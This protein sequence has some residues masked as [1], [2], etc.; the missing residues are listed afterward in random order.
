MNV[1][2]IT[3]PE[4]K[5]IVSKLTEQFGITHIPQLL[6]RTGKDKIRAFSGHMSKDE[7]TKLSQLARVEIIG[8]YVMREE[9][10][11]RLSL[12]GALLFKEQISKNKLQISKEQLDQWMRG[13][14]LQQKHLPGM[15][16]VAY[17]SD[18][19]GCGRS[20]GE[21]VTNFVPKD[22]RVRQKTSLLPKG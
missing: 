11:L 12:D 2:F 22:R 19:V 13:E 7:L 3:S 18:L 14:E 10:E 1:Q 16:V 8:L 6:I 9:E 5:K 21:K 15:Y 4:K 20:T 17:E